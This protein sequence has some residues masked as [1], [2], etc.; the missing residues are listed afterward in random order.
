MPPAS[1]DPDR[2]RSLGAALGPLRESAGEGAE[3]A[4]AQFPE[5]GDRE[6]QAVLDGWVEQMADLLREIE[7]TASDLA[8]RLRVAAL[9]ADGSAATPTPRHEPSEGAWTES[10]SASGTRMSNAFREGFR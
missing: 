5:V 4:L 1:V 6:T 9:G 10:A 2:L 7:A 8:D 3:E